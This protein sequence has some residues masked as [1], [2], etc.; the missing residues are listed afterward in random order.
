MA[1]DIG[2]YERRLEQE[3]AA[4]AAAQTEETRHLHDELA[5]LYRKM[6]VLLKQSADDP[7]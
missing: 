1:D 2:Y 5:E 4:A 6:L 7:A 3:R